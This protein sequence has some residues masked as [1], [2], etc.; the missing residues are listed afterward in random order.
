[1]RES[2]FVLS[3]ALIAIALL[4]VI[5]GSVALIASQSAKQ[6]SDE[7]TGA[8]LDPTSV[9]AELEHELSL[10]VKSGGISPDEHERITTELD[11][12]TE[13]GASAERIAKMRELL[14]RLDVGGSR[15]SSVVR[16][17][18]QSQSPTSTLKPPPPAPA[19]P[20]HSPSSP[21]PIAPS[22]DFF[23][24]PLYDRTVCPD[25][26]EGNEVF[27]RAG[28]RYRLDDEVR[29][30]AEEFCGPNAKKSLIPPP[31]PQP[32][33]PPQPACESNPTPVFTDHI[34]DMSKV[35]YIGPP[36]TMGA[37]PN[38]KTHSYI[39]TD[40]ARVPVY[41]PADM[42]LESGSHYVGGPYMVEFRASCEVKVRFGH[43]TEPVEKIKN[44]LP[45]E[46]K[47]DSRTQELAPIHFAA[48]ELVGYTTGTDVAGNWDFGV[49]NS[50]VRNRY[51]DDPAWNWSAIN[52]TAVCPFD[53]FP[54][55]MRAAY[56]AKF[57]SA[58]L[59]GNPPH[60]EPFCR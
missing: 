35:N 37:G 5:G 3:P 31:P 34:T 1:M 54:P 32:S 41:A 4:M 29:R 7:K 11:R 50:T 48:G 12:L 39:G 14:A 56:V 23:S 25:S 47:P 57:N 42:T 21:T 19:S 13:A 22:F 10:A 8:A 45:S 6:R 30:W 59:G 9:L 26:S 46:A 38:L 52:T 36:P 33:G 58:A 17:T 55:E 44:L 27:V 2:G 60:G 43:M 20:L 51:V 18:H 16:S 28:V 24:L 53:Y 40:H 15:A 49:Y